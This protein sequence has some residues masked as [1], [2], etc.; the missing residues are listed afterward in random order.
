MKQLTLNLKRR[1][2]MDSMYIAIVNGEVAILYYDKQKYY[3]LSKS[4]EM[5][6]DDK[7]ENKLSFSKYFSHLSDKTNS[8]SITYYYDGDLYKEKYEKAVQ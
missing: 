4:K 8:N 6:D 3:N 7:V 5:E 1:L 2:D